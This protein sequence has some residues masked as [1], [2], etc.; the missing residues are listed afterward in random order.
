ML[1]AK[2]IDLAGKRLQLV[3]AAGRKTNFLQI[4][5]SQSIR[6]WPAAKI[7][8]QI[9]TNQPPPKPIHDALPQRAKV[10]IVALCDGNE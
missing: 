4:N 6:Q 7:E 9:K 8:T 10:Q 3:T 1:N 5:E 2:Q